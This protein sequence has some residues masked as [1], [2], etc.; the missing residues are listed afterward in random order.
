M[1]EVDKVDEADKVEAE[2]K[3]NTHRLHTTYT[4]KRKAEVAVETT[5]VSQ[6]HQEVQEQLAN[7]QRKA[8]HSGPT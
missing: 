7:P 8:E 4:I 3:S 5:V 1:D 6:L 2:D